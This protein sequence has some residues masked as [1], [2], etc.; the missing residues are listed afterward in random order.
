MTSQ[1]SPACGQML[2]L[3]PD[4]LLFGQDGT[5]SAHWMCQRK[6]LIQL[7]YILDQAFK[8]VSA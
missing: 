7:R 3:L 5:G 6:I 2:F 4:P 8:F 1:H